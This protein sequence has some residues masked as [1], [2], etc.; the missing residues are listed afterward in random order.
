MQAPEMLT[1]EQGSPEW[2][3]IRRTKRTAS[4]AGKVMQCSPYGGWESLKAYYAGEDT[5]K[6]NAATKFGNDNEPAARRA[7]NLEFGFDFQPEVFV[8]GDYLASLDGFDPEFNLNLEIKCPAAGR[9]S[10]TWKQACQFGTVEPHYLWQLHHQMFV[11]GARAT[12][13]WVYDPIQKEGI[14]VIVARDE[15]AIKQLL[16]QWD[17][18]FAWMESGKEAPEEIPD[19]SGDETFASAAAKFRHFKE[20]KD[21]ADKALENARE[22]LM[23]ALGERPKGYA[24]G[25]TVQAV[26]KR[27]GVDYKAIPQL[28]GVDLD[29]FRKADITEYRVTLK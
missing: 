9:S 1:L 22:S 21:M 8:R 12:R 4:N 24:H 25:V 2:H 11:S 13:F 27:G 16:E 28:K 23:A 7:Y 10:K 5:F 14:E 6:G 20:L 26:T 3:L 29:Q 19:L 17:A 18:F 15:A